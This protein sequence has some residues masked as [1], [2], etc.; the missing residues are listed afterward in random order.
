MSNLPTD[1][2]GIS[3]TNSN[4]SGSHHLAKFGSRWSR[5]SSALADAPSFS[6][7][8]AIGRSLHFSSGI[9]ITAASSTAGCAMSAVSSSIED[10]HSP[11]DLIT[12][13]VRSVSVRY[14][15]SSITPTSPVRSQPSWNRSSDPGAL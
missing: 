9:P 11:P 7:T 5:S 10:T 2:L 12:S 15:C 4:R 1:V 13:L 6:T 3:E 14:P 8:H